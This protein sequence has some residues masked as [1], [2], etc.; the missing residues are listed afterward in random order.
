[1]IRI[2]I[3]EDHAIVREGLKQLIAL[4][5][6]I[7]VVDEARTGREALDKALSSDIDVLLLD[8]YLPQIQGMDVL[9][10]LQNEAH[11]FAVLVLSMQD[12]AQFAARALKAGASGYVTKDSAP[13][14]LLAAIRKVAAGGKFIDP[15]LVDEMVFE[16]GLGETKAPH[17][18]LSDRE[19]Q[20]L[21]MIASGASLN[22]IAE[23]MALSAKTIS[24]Y[25]ARLMRKLGVTSNAELIRYALDHKLIGDG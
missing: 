23:K 3:A 21:R 6:D 7:V 25:K 18:L 4:V 8:M 13:E 1:M 22:A 15:A 12:E 14:V 10:R 16:V 5:P 11:A 2:L 20:V 19:D 24:S 9:K 17:A